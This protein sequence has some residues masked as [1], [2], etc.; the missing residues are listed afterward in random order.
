MRRP[1]IALIRPRFLMPCLPLLV[2]LAS[3]V[4]AA[5]VRL[6]SA[7]DESDFLRLRLTPPRSGISMD[8]GAVASGANNIGS[9]WEITDDEQPPHDFSG[10]S[11]YAVLQTTQWMRASRDDWWIVYGRGRR[12]TYE[13]NSD[14]AQLWIDLHSDSR[15][16]DSY[17][18]EMFG[19]SI[20]A[21]WYG[22]GR[23]IPIRVGSAR[24]TAD[25]FVR[26][27]TADEYIFRSVVGQVEGEDY[28][29]ITRAVTSNTSSGD[30]E[31]RGWSLDVRA[32]FALG[33][34]WHGQFT[35]ESLMGKVSWEGLSVEDSYITSPGVFQDADG[36]LHD[37]GGITGMGWRDDRSATTQPKY[38]IDLMRTGRTDT[39]LGV[40]WEPGLPATVCAGAA[41]PQR[42]SWLPYCRFY[43]PQERLEIGAL[44]R[45][46]Y[47]RVSGDDWIF[48]SPQHAEIACGVRL[49]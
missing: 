45:G 10:S 5:T 14:A 30:V 23:T 22:V 21:T 26:N 8:V 34:N 47:L 35:A 13:G 28:T 1:S 25:V 19:T 46:W 38:R 24:G 36:F 11:A 20:S 4:T 29:G 41:W 16:L 17:A 12:D 6:P 31:G 3:S 18:P 15:S 42:G 27:I 9:L 49:D 43:L 37:T 32:S 2:L 39:L 44:G 7:F 48:A 33:R 40:A